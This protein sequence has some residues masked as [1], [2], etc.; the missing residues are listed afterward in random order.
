MPII[1]ISCNEDF[2]QVLQ[3]AQVMFIAKPIS[4]S[5]LYSAVAHYTS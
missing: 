3:P 4:L 5:D 2:R 1:V